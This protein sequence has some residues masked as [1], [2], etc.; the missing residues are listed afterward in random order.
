MTERGETQEQNAKMP[1]SIYLHSLVEMS[2][3]LRAMTP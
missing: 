3:G 2:A 1:L